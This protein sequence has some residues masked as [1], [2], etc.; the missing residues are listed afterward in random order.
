MRLVLI[1]GINQQGKSSDVLAKRW[2]GALRAGAG[3][4]A[5]WPQQTLSGID[6]PFYGDRLFALAETK[7]DWSTVSQGADEA[8]DEFTEFA[9]D[10]FLQMA[11]Q[12]GVSAEQLRS[13][14]G[15]GQT[16]MGAGPHKKWLKALARLME[17]R[18]PGLAKYALMLLKQAHAYLKRPHI[19][20]QVDDIVRPAL[21]T[22]EEMVIVSHS[23]GTVVSYALLRELAAEAHPVSCKL[24]VTLGSPLGIDEIRKSFPLPRN[25]PQGVTHWL[26]GSDPEDFV[27]LHG[28][29][30]PPKYA[31][32]IEN[33]V[34]IDNGSADPH[35]IEGYLRDIRVAKAIAEAV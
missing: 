14:V 32:G 12:A 16:P 15:E 2:L 26:N 27:A 9:Y 13:E 10:A 8:D 21:A 28:T 4:D 1:H 25:V 18:M 30:G 5:N 19:K 17:H 3:Q 7:T 24:Y 6:V 31:D 11:I 34:D 35:D 29:I 23:L 22:D 33:V 20:R